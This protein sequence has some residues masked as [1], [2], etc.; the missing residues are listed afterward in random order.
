[1]RTL[2]YDNTIDNEGLGISPKNYELRRRENFKEYQDISL[3]FL[4]VAAVIFRTWCREIRWRWY[5]VIDRE[6]IRLRLHE[7][8]AHVF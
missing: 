5:E 3:Y 2:G 8:V 1:M 4:K 7:P 6:L